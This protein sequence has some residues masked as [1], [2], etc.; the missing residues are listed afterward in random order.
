MKIKKA[1]NAEVK[2]VVFLN[3]FVQKIHAD[4]YPKI[5]KYPKNNEEVFQFFKSI[6][7]QKSNYILIAQKEDIPVGYIWATLE[8][9]SENPF[10]YERNYFYI[11]QLVVHEQ[12]RHQGIGNK[13]VNEISIIADQKGII[14]IHLDSWFFNKSAHRFFEKIGFTTYNLNMWRKQ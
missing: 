5:F 14:D 9:K 1:T 3:T 2:D 4:K 12:Y 6:I 11:H 10:K 7:D 13:L 8:H